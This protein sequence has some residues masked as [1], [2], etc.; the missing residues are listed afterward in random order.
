MSASSSCSQGSFG[1]GAGGGGRNPESDVRDSL[2]L[3]VG[4][5]WGLADLEH[6]TFSSLERGLPAGHLGY[7]T[8]FSLL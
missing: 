4:N 1:R 3:P 7:A 6:E 5:F 8:D 2:G